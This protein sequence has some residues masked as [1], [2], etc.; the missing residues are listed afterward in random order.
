MGA[1]SGAVQVGLKEKEDGQRADSL[2]C[3]AVFD[4][5]QLPAGNTSIT[6]AGKTLKTIKPPLSYRWEH[7]AGDGTS[8]K[9]DIDEH[10]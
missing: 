9:D 8:S 4:T 7:D 3:E 10:Y 2:R 5:E 1:Q 6:I